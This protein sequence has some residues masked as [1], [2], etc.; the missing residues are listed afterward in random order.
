MRELYVLYVWIV[1]LYQSSVIGWFVL[2]VYES[3]AVIGWHVASGRTH[4]D[5]VSAVIG[6][7]EWREVY[8]TAC[9]D[10]PTS[11]YSDTSYQRAIV[12]TSTFV[13]RLSKVRV[14]L[15]VVAERIRSSWPV[16]AKR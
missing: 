11:C 16:K 13:L 8:N 1:T 5:A 10:R 7:C 3:S 12:L 15:I 6:R 9:V 2:G 14:L 4:S